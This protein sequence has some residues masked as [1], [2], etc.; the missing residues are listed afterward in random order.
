MSTQ[1]TG[2][3]SYVAYD[4]SG[5][6]VNPD[7]PHPITLQ[8]CPRPLNRVFGG[9]SG[10][11]G[12]SGGTATDFNT[13]IQDNLVNLRARTGDSIG[14]IIFVAGNNHLYVYDGAD[15]VSFNLSSSVSP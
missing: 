14:T 1:T 7:H 5:N 4:S 11:S 12:G 2:H 8:G 9:G 10:G 15:W 13:E 3:I 6:I